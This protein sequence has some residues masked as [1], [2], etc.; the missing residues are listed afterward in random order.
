MVRG[1]TYIFFFTCIARANLLQSASVLVIPTVRSG[2]FHQVR[3]THIVLAPVVG[4][5]A[6]PPPALRRPNRNKTRTLSALLI[7]NEVIG[8][9]LPSFPIPR[10]SAPPLHRLCRT[11]SANR[12]G[13]NQRRNKSL[14]PLPS[15][16]QSLVPTS[17]PNPRA[18]VLG[19]RE[20]ARS[21]LDRLPV[22][23]SGREEE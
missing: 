8:K 12:L 9:S 17:I 3:P 6:S 21:L 18:A 23:Y 2:P 14:A 10:P 13:N 7:I 15:L 20:N 4:Y 11:L 16:S 1:T 5:R 19:K 22:E